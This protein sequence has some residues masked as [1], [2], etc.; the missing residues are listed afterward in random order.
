MF[1]SLTAQIGQ[2]ELPKG[3]IYELTVTKSSWDEN[4]GLTIEAKVIGQPAATEIVF[5]FPAHHEAAGEVRPKTI[6]KSHA[7]SIRPGSDRG[8][9]LDSAF[10]AHFQ[11][12]PDQTLFL[13]DGEYSAYSGLSLHQIASQGGNLLIEAHPV[14]GK[15]DYT[16][17]LI[18]D[19][20]AGKAEFKLYASKGELPKPAKSPQ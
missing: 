15:L 11:L 2:P 4:V 16:H 10:R 3:L 18:Y 17:R 19:K 6:A 8:A 13:K 14:P 1:T 20:A 9:E 5:H 7:I 12:A